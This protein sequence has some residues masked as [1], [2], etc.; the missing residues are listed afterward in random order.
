MEVTLNGIF[1]SEVKIYT[2]P[3]SYKRYMLV[4]VTKIPEG[5]PMSVNPRSQNMGSKAVK[6]M[7][8]SLAK[9]EADFSLK[10][11]GIKIICRSIKNV[12][13]HSISLN[14][15]DEKTQGVVDGGHTY[16]TITEFI[17]SHP[18]YRSGVCVFVEIMY[19]DYPVQNCVEIAAA[20][21]T[22]SQVKLISIMNAQGKF[23]EV[24][25]AIKNLPFHNDIIWEENMEGRIKGEFII[26]AMQLFNIFQFKNGTHPC[27][28]YNSQDN[29]L[30]AFDRAYVANEGITEKN[31]F[32]YLIP[33]L[34]EILKMHDYVQ[35]SI[36]SWYNSNEGCKYGSLMEGD[37]TYASISKN[38]SFN[39]FLTQMSMKY[40]TPQMM[41]FPILSVARYCLEFK[42]NKLVW[43]IDP[44]LFLNTV[45]PAVTR[46]LIKDMM[47]YKDRHKYMKL[48]TTWSNVYT[49][50]RDEWEKAT[51]DTDTSDS[52]INL[53]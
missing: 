26:A 28:S 18:N 23:M 24:K 17:S 40:Y 53:G 46:T 33:M 3:V 4:D 39:T 41:V 34:P 11:G 21:N 1:T 37:E 42:N 51:T 47:D 31:P 5:I 6:N 44:H 20:R 7:K 35:Q 8:D 36:A 25:E 29:C 45:G 2:N 22:S 15:D 13:L 10:N 50:A 19:G 52:F 9:H 30:K 12:G 14:I 43:R 49:V 27:D 16:R 38:K 32:Y 48:P